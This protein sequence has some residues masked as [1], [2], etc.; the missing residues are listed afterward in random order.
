MT[1]LEFKWLES[2]QKLQDFINHNQIPLD[3]I[4]VSFSGGKDSTI[5]LQMIDELG[6]KNKIKVVFFNTLMEWNGIYEFVDL[7][8]QQGW[9]IEETKPEL[10]A[11]LIYKKFGKPLKSK[12]ASEM[13]YRLQQKNFDFVNDTYKSYEELTLKYHK[14]ESAL[15]WITGHNLF[16]MQCPKWLKQA[17]ANGEIQFKVANKCC[18]YLK[19][20]PVAKWN[21]DNDI[22]LSILG[23]RSSENGIRSQIYKSCLYKNKDN[24]YKYFPLFHFNDKD[25]DDIIKL[26]NI[27]VSKCYTTYG[28]ERTGCVGCPYA[29]YYNN[30]LEVLKKYEPNKYVAVMNMFGDV[31]KIQDKKGK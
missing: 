9:I 4:A 26:K 21:K 3:K 25:I 8:R 27:E 30:E 15:K 20:K 23:I 28:L 12:Y 17:L 18:E 22:Q 5:V 6:L 11:P 24:T 14:C 16:T 19:K 31:Y 29:H 10:P 2:K 13:I 7:K 1:D